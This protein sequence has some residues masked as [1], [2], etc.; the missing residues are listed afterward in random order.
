MLLIGELRTPTHLKVWTNKQYPEIM[1]YCYDGS[2]FGVTEPSASITP[3]KQV[4]AL[5]QRR[6]R[7]N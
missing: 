3:I 6:R 1:K 4:T 5:P 2:N 7:K